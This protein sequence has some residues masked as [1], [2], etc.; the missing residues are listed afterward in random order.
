MKHKNK[1]G[2]KTVRS[3]IIAV[4]E[5]VEDKLSAEMNAAGMGYIVYDGWTKFGE[6]YFCLFTTY[7][8]T[9]LEVDK[10]C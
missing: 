6:H 5:I 9:R 4:T 3:V 2:K 7:M 8:T 10:E 1:F